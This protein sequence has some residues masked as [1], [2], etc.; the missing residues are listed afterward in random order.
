MNTGGE[1]FCLCVIFKFTAF[2]NY[3]VFFANNFLL[4]RNAPVFYLFSKSPPRLCKLTK[5]TPH[6][7]I[8]PAKRKYAQTATASR[9]EFLPSAT[10]IFESGYVQPIMFFSPEADLRSLVAILYVRH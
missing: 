7:A 9:A 6:I 5:N 3:I 10:S 1:N 8:L 2:K 4:P